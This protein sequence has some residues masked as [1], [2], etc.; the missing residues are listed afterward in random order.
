MRDFLL[1]GD[2]EGEGQLT[3]LHS[4]AQVEEIRALLG[5]RGKVTELEEN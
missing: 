4:H 3:I 2:F 1:N 5:R